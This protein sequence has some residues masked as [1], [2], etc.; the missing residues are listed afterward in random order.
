MLQFQRKSHHDMPHDE[1]HD[2][3]REIVG[4]VMVKFLAA[5]IAM[6]GNF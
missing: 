2:I 5:N 6:I 1:D 3:G 4:A